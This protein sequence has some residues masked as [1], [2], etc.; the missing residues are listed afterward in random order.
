MRRTG[1]QLYAV[2]ELM[3]VHAARAGPQAGVWG[4]SGT[5]VYLEGAELSNRLLLV[6][7]AVRLLLGLRGHEGRVHR[8]EGITEA[9]EHLCAEG[10]S[11]KNGSAPPVMGH[12]GVTCT[13]AQQACPC[14]ARRENARRAVRTTQ[15]P[16]PCSAAPGEAIP[17]LYGA[18]SLCLLFFVFFHRILDEDVTTCRRRGRRP[19]PP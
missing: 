14:V 12:R 5:R 7:I 17:R 19:C 15:T 11:G 16:A 8:A 9:G 13:R 10:V 6:L 2:R 18:L 3:T 1:P 4:L